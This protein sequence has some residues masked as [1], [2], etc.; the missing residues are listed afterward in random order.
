MIRTLGHFLNRELF[1]ITSSEN[2]INLKSH[3]QPLSCSKKIWLVII[4]NSRISR[5][6]SEIS[7]FVVIPVYLLEKNGF[8]ISLEDLS[9]Y[10]NAYFYILTF[11]SRNI[12]YK[13]ITLTPLTRGEKKGFHQK[14][15]LN[16]IHE[17]E[18]T[19]FVHFCSKF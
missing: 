13:K 18:Q 16:E 4:S 2:F 7:H 12:F 14:F 19:K 10:V 3:L 5:K 11:V 15:L 8:Y 1:E 6:F 17:N 9:F